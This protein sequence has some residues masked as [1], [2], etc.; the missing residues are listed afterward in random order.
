VSADVI[1]LD[2]P[3]DEKRRETAK[4]RHPAKGTRP[5]AE[6]GEWVALLDGLGLLAPE[7]GLLRAE[8]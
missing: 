6:L 2:P 4:R 7:D 1:R 8:P 3:G 5:L